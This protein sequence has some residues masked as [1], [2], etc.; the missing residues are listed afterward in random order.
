MAAPTVVKGKDGTVS[1]DGTAYEGQITTFSLS[2]ASDVVDTT[3][4]GN[5]WKTNETTLKSWSG[6]FTAKFDGS[7]AQ[8]EDLEDALLSGDNIATVFGYGKNSGDKTYSGNIK[9]TGFDSSPATEGVIELS[10]G[11]TGNGELTPATKA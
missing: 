10:I 5:D 6:S 3:T 4:M 7:N 8:Q 2:I 9:V 1:I 11:F